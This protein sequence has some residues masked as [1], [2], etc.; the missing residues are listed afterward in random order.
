VEYTENSSHVN[1]IVVDVRNRLGK[2]EPEKRS[3][4]GHVKDVALDIVRRQ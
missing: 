3:L 4:K 2:M 1:L